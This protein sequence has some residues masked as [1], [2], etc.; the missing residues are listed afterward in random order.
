MK[1]YKS[2]SP[3]DRLQQGQGVVV[4]GIQYGL[5]LAASIALTVATGVYLW[6][7]ENDVDKYVCKSLNT[8]SGGTSATPNN[9]DYIKVN[10]RF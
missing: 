8:G 9:D 6:S 1:K 7:V 4:M 3:A 2:M 5:Y 10:E